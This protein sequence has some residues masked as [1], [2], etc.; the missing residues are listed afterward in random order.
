[1]PDVGVRGAKDVR[2]HVLAA[3]RGAMLSPHEL[4]EVLSTLR[5][6]EHV[7]RL[8]LE[9]RPDV[10]V[11]GAKDVRRHVKAAERGVMLSPHEL[12]EVLATLRAS[13]HVSRL[14]RKVSEQFP[15]L[16]SLAV[17]LPIRPGLEGRIGESI[18]DDG[19][20][21]DSASPDLRR[22]RAQILAAQQ[23]LQERLGTLVN[24]YRSAL[25]EPIITTRSDRYVLPVRAEAR[26]QVKGI[27][28]DQSGSGATLFIEPAV[29]VEM[30]NRLRELHLE[31]QREIERILTEL[32][33]AVASDGPY[34]TLAVELLAEIDLHLAKARYAGLLRASAPKVSDDGRLLLRKARHPLLRGNVV[35]ID[36]WLGRAPDDAELRM[37]VITGPNTGGKTVALKTVGLLSLM[38]QAG[39]HIPCEDGSAIPVY[40]D[41][42]ADI[43][44]EQSIEQS[45]STFSSHL[46]RIVEILRLATSESLVLLDELGAG[47]DP[48][49]GS[50][51]ARAILAH[52]LAQ[53]VNTVAT[54][55]YSELKVFAHEQS[56]VANASVEFDV[57]TLSPTYRLSI[58]LPGRSNALAIATR[59]GLPGDIISDA[60]DY[61]GSAGVEMESLLANLQAERA[62]ASDERYHLSMERAEAE[63]QRRE[64]EKLRTEAEE[65]RARVLNEARAQARREVEE[66]RAELARVRTQMRRKLTEEQLTQLRERTRALEERSAPVAPKTRHRPPA[67]AAPGAAEPVSISGP[68]EVGD[69][70]LVRSMGQ[71]GEVVA[72][73]NSRGEVE[74]QIGALKLR[75]PESQVERLSRRQARMVDAR[76]LPSFSA[77]REAT[78]TPE[79]Q[80][81]LRGWRVDDA[82]EEVDRYLNNAALAGM[83]FVRIL[84]GKGT[85]ALRQAIRQ[86]LSHHPLV[87]SQKSA[88][89][90]DGGDGI[91]VVTL[92]N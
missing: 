11:R 76:E 12:V 57:E 89:A 16:W 7:S 78:P 1:R 2:R 39:M 58:G 47:T 27:V 70:V 85:G 13:E 41:V 71:R 24:T 23:H 40:S 9:Q 21:L 28:H 45:L 49:E 38:A 72:L 73:P 74:V 32:S 19:D 61:V 59:L 86:E 56:G 68:L 75:A 53:G 46:T 90:K 3:E 17:D 55:H 14:L 10:G 42:F 81:D 64:A 22:I 82:L 48:S 20:V 54:T 92:A 8:L 69:T 80:L 51:L 77:P 44:D 63:Y 31:E 52:L 30:N 65:E 66:T 67:A 83:P 33:E 87:K 79:L 50:A 25:Q 29:V 60:R 91:T 36:F 88:E 5:A 62:A 26:G 37:V 35:P 6:S 15:L 18:S 34:V 4:V 43:G 84:H